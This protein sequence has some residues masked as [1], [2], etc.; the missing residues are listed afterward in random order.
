MLHTGERGREQGH[1]VMHGVDTKQRGVPD[2]IGDAR[3]QNV[4]TESGIER[5]VG[6]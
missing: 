3:P 5:Q 2:S 4:R 6:G 1:F